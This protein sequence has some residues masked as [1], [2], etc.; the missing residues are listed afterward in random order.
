MAW[1]W[2]T[3]FARQ[4]PWNLAMEVGYVGRRGIHNQRKRNIN[5]LQTGA[6]FAN[7][8]VNVNALRPYLG[9]GIIGIA[10]NSGTSMYNGLQ[11]SVERRFSSGLGFGVAYTL[12]K[13]TDNS[14]DL[15]DVLPDTYNDRSYQGISDL[16]RPH[17][18]IIN[19]IYEL[20]FLRDKKNVLG[21]TLGG[22]ELSGMNQWQSGSPF[23]VR[24]TAD[25]AGVG[26]GSGN[27][28]Y[29]QIGDPNDVTKTGFTDSAVWFNKAAF[30]RPANGTWGNQPRNGIMNPG[31]WAFDIGIR[32]NFIT[33]EKQRLQ[34]RGEFFNLLNRVNYRPPNGNRSSGAFGTITSTYDPRVIQLALKASF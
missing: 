32:K 20:P 31:F 5:Q 12:S 18:L 4:L 25:N 8:G 21:K 34:V 3:T 19:Y 29:N 33:A 10:E 16:N 13:A 9:M 26:T 28:F 6:V 24:H 7:P 30:A 23:S 1:N 27:Q 11:V 2:N 22:W 14:S 17:V 15:T